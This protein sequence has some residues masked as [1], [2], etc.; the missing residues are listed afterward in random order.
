MFTLPE[1][2]SLGEELLQAANKGSAANY[3]S[4]G[5]GLTHEHSLMVQLFY[6]GIF[7][8][9][10]T[11]IGD[12]VNYA[13]SEYLRRG[14]INSGW[15]DS[16]LYSFLLSGDPAMQLLRSSLSLDKSVDKAM[17]LR[18]EM[19]DYTF[20]VTNDGIFPSVATIVDHLPSG[21]S[22]VSSSSSVPSDVNIDGQVLSATFKY[23][24]ET[25]D[26]GIPWNESAVLTVTALINNSASPGW[27]FNNAFVTGT[28]FEA[29]EEDNWDSAELYTCCQLNLPFLP[30]EK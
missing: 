22:Y 6:D 28:G 26:Y 21:L 1:N 8:D 15:H 9:G 16:I 17:A 5:L 25:S 27:I 29:F 2:E 11:A 20:E 3:S 24:A 23:G 4:T 14:V 19:V 12:A 7:L 13:K 30:K 10:N 18:G